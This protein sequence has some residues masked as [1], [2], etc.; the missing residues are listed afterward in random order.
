MRKCNAL[1]A[2]AVAGFLSLPSVASAQGAIAGVA[3]DTT[4]AVLPGV[5]VQAVS[6]ALI[7]GGRGVITDSAGQYSIVNLRPGTYTVTFTLPGF[8][9]YRR[10]N[11]LLE[12]NFTAQVNAEMRIG[13]LP[14]PLP[15]RARRRRRRQERRG[16]RVL[17]RRSS[18]NSRRCA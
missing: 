5:T 10:E 4:G 11:I 1:F 13:E 16:N 8:S 17:T 7:E 2:A 14:S 9:V 15:S 18:P 12:A 6:P 3:K